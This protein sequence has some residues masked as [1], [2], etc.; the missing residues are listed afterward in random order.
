MSR[1]RT[2]DLC[3]VTGLSGV[4][5]FAFLGD[6]DP[7]EVDV[8]AIRYD[9]RSAVPGCYDATP[10]YAGRRGLAAYRTRVRV[11]DETLRRVVFD[12]VHHRCRV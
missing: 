8:A 1:C 9:D 12:G 5:D 3:L 6:V 7:D 11:A 4:W 10:A 2:H